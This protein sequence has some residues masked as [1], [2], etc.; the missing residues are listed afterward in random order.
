MIDKDYLVLGVCMTLIW[1]FLLKRLD[2]SKIYKI[3]PYSYILIHYVTALSM[4]FIGLVFLVFLLRLD[5][6]RFFL[7]FFIAIDFVLL[8]CFIIGVYFYAKIQ[9]K[10]GLYNTNILVMGDKNVGSFINKIES[11]PFWGYKIKGIVTD[12]PDLREKYESMY[13]IYSVDS[14]KQTLI[15]EPIDELYYCRSSL[16]TK[17]VS[18]LI[19]MC[20]EIGVTFRLSSQILSL[21][22]TKSKIYYLGET[23]YFTFQNTPKQTFNMAMKNLF[24]KVFAF[25]V[26]VC[27]SPVFIIIAIC[28]K[29][30]SKGPVF[31]KQIRSGLR[32]REFYVYKFRSMCDGAEAML[33]SMKD[34]NEQEGPVFKVKNDKRITKIGSFLR[35]TSLDELPQFINVLKGDMSV[36]GPRPPLPAEV[37]QYKPW[38]TR[39]LSMKPGITCIWQ[40]SGRN[41]IPF[42]QWMKLDLQYIDTWSLGLDFMIILKTVKT[43]LKHDGQ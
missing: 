30:D 4:G 40:V 10:K 11:N 2:V 35:K 27:L 33:D 34:E 5:I 16:D 28:I 8:Y 32:G 37:K 22:Q 26:L 24:D 38:Q 7:L 17:L 25:C 39:R 29:L 23:P 42:E 41:N 31:F 1:A 21:A 3:N 14:L 19:Y 18:D 36:V 15:E 12:S 9:R 20:L 6:N 43:V 13:T